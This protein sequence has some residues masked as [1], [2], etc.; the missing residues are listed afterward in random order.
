[1]RDHTF[2]IGLSVRLKYR[3][4]ISP[5]RGRDLSHHGQTAVDIQLAPVSHS[6]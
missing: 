1:M 2:P 6:Q 5:R 4:Y 3:T